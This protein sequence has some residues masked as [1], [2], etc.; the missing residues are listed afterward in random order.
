[1]VKVLRGLPG[2]VAVLLL[3]A[4]GAVAQVERFVGTYSGS[5]EVEFA[6]G[7]TE[8]RDMSVEIS[9][10]KAGFAVEWSSITFRRDGKAKVKSYRIDFLASERDGV[11]SAAM[12]QNLFGH[13][14]PLDP[15]KG[16][17]YVWGRING[18]TL[19]VFSMF[20]TE[21]GGYE[22]QQFDRTLA[23]GGM[24]LDFRRFRNG[25]EQRAVNT[26]L[27]REE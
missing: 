10:T 14:V 24:T 26:F 17:P 4:G 2:M 6:D 7:T 11:F 15:M 1:M 19:T 23:D 20:I 13:A 12:R 5:A 16:E 25:V 21:D 9:K 3:M 22:M 27:R 18:D 8:P